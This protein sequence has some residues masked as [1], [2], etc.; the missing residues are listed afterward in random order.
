MCNCL[1]NLNARHTSRL[2]TDFLVNTS[3]T[4]M[5]DTPLNL[6]LGLV[7]LDDADVD[8]DDDDRLTSTLFGF[9]KVWDVR[10]MKDRVPNLNR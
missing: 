5:L 10:G 3:S 7:L 2:H 6:G 9:L 4:L 1:I 8:D